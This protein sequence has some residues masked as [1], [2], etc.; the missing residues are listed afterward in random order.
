MA[1]A[2]IDYMSGFGRVNPFGNVLQGL[3]AGAQFAGLE[4]QQQAR[5]LQIQEAQRAQEQRRAAGEAFNALMSNPNPTH[6]D[7]LRVSMLLPKDQSDLLMKGFE[8]QN[9]SQQGATLSRSAQVMSAFRSN[10][11]DVG[12]RLLTEWR[13]AEANA[14]RD[15]QA[16]AINTIIEVSNRDPKMVPAMI[17]AIMA[18]L[19]GSKELIDNLSKLALAE[20]EL[21]SAVAAA[22]KAEADAKTAGVTAEYARPV[23]IAGLGKAQADAVTAQ[24]TAAVAPELAR[25]GVQQTQTN[26]RNLESTISDRSQRLRL[27]AQRLA[28]ETTNILSQIQER[29]GKIPEAA[30]KGVNDAAVAAASAKQQSERLSGLARDIT[31]IGTSW[32]SLGSA[33]EWLKR[34]T[35][36][37][38]A[39][40][41]LRQEYT[42]LRNSLAIQALPPGPATDKDIQL[43]MSGFPPETANP[44]V[45]SSFLN[46][47]A[48]MQRLTSE[49][50]SARAD[51]LTNNRGSL[52]RASTTFQA[53]NFAARQGETF[54]DFGTR[55]AAELSRPPAGSMARAIEQIPGVRA[56][57]AAAPAA[58]AG[59]SI[60]EQADAILRGGAR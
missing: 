38:G 11:P 23:A 27:D 24:A 47:M 55:I 15:D 10:A 36:S 44:Q 18:P 59:P 4:Q 31:Q 48:K 5:A 26:I 56:P 58:P 13:D 22:D 41:E 35:G 17:G 28:L 3:E 43:A 50:E 6:S 33:A 42:R 51:W 60:R 29:S 54:A 9:K 34:S 20:P 53:G 45:I 30:Q 2:P 32:G 1:Q 57:A 7:Y 8:A 40:T 37:Q 49:V 21:R 46:G 52:G 16:R 25:L 39:I 14:G 12:G 19:P